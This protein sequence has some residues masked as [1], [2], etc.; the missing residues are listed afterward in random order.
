MAGS[1]N[2][3]IVAAASD[4]VSTAQSAPSAGA[5]QT[6]VSPSVP[7]S[8]P[9]EKPPEPGKVS[10][11]KLIV[12]D[13]G[14]QS[15]GNS[16]LEPVGPGASEMKAKVSSGTVGRYTGLPEYQLN[17]EV[18]LK[19]QTALEAAGYDVVMVRATNDVDISNSERAELANE[20]GADAFIRIHANGSESPAENGV[21]TICQTRDNPYN[22][23]IYDACRALSRDILAGV[24]T[25]T[26]A[27]DRGIWETDTMSGINWCTVP[28]TI[29]E[30]GYMTNEK[31]DKLLSTDTYQDLIVRGILDGLASFFKESAPAPAQ[32]PT[33]AS[34]SGAVVPV[35]QDLSELKEKLD[36]SIGSLASQW[37]VYVECLNDG[38]A[39][40]CS[41]NL[42]KDG[43][44]VSASI[45]KIF[46]MGAVYE[47]ISLGKLEEKDVSSD[48]KR[49]I[50]VSD[51]DA[52][53]RLIT[54]LGKGDSGK[55][56]TL[57]NQFAVSLG[58]RQ[59]TLNRLMLDWDEGLENYTSASDCAKLLR[60]IYLG[61]CVNA[62]YSEKMMTLLKAQEKNEGL[63]WPIP[64]DV[65]VAS[66]PGFISGVSIGDVGIVFSG[67]AD[68][69]IC[70]ICNKPYSDDGAKQ[71][72]C[73]ISELV[74]EYFAE[75]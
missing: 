67:H 4:A 11:K 64:E 48:L 8:Q 68:Y 27:A 23:A 50:T 46:I 7:E 69:I 54:L 75:Q 59:T 22:G 2:A 20:A 56:F 15:A 53:N 47:Q 24:V 61:Q 42:P 73:D 21:L 1:T 71:K 60:L 72:I 12:I 38:A 55:G 51:N 58:C 14:H 16:G 37:D 17:L 39:V 63:K 19:L 41:Q 40:N 25:A 3:P 34:P 29:L 9:S 13:A 62:V 35:S 45:I 18:A 32:S 43:R 66:K 28:V 70:V 36:D 57:M 49:M 44:M 74:F 6:A 10:D 31:E 65:V 26:G 33:P 52:T 5:A 30:M